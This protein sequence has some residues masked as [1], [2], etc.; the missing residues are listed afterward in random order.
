MDCPST[1]VRRNKR[2]FVF[3][4]FILPLQTFDNIHEADALIQNWH[5]VVEKVSYIIGNPPF[6][7]YSMQ[8]K[9]QKE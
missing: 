8:T 4:Y 3:S 1:N 6:A 2:Q 5:D 9:L 7:G